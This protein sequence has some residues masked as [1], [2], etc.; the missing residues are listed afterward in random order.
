M[1]EDLQK[2][3]EP[4]NRLSISTIQRLQEWLCHVLVQVWRG[5]LDDPQVFFDSEPALF[6]RAAADAKLGIVRDEE[7]NYEHHE[8][9]CE[10]YEVEIK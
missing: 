4:G 9:T 8:N 2:L 7:G 3:L 5:L 1:K 6:A 10:L